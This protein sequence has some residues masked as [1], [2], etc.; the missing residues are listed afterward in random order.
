MDNDSHKNI[1]TKSNQ[2]SYSRENILQM[3]NQVKYLSCDVTLPIET[4]KS[5]FQKA[6]NTFNPDNTIDGI[7]LCAGTSYALPFDEVNVNVFND[8]HQSNVMGSVI[9]AQVVLPYIKN[10]G[11]K[12]SGS[13][14]FIS[15]QAGQVGLYGY[16]AYSASKFAIKGVAE[17][18]AMELYADNITVSIA[19]PPDTDTAGY[20]AEMKTKPDILR[21]LSEFGALFQPE[22]VAY[23]VIK[24]IMRREYQIFTGLDGWMIA[25]LTSG[26]SPCSNLIIGLVDICTMSILRLVSIVYTQFFYYLVYQHKVRQGE[27]NSKPSST[28]TK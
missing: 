27:R 11:R 2:S 28:I 4:V 20:E 19:F 16:T 23:D 9:P 21:Q 5:K 10:R 14:T 8:L 26:F 7:V 12:S 3:M 15:S 18:L 17:S 24:G 13:V 22:V 25:K 1:S 6:I